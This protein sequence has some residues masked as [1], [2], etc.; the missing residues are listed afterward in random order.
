MISTPCFVPA[1]TMMPRSI[2][3]ASGGCRL[4]AL[5][6]RKLISQKLEVFHLL[7]ELGE[8]AQLAEE[9]LERRRLAEA[10]DVP[11]Q[12]VPLD[13]DDVVPGFLDR[14]PE[15]PAEAMGGRGQ[16][17]ADAGVGG[18]EGGPLVSGQVVPDVLDDHRT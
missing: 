17:F 12:R 11:G 13:P 6:N 4:L 9:D 8:D 15:L 18:L 16:D 2:W 7:A 5:G 1:G 10:L 3:P 14:A